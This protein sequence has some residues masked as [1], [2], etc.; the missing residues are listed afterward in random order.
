MAT[1]KVVAPPQGALP[2]I[3]S[4]SATK[5]VYFSKGNL[6]ATCT[7][8]GG[9]GT[10]TYSWNFAKHQYDYVGDKAGNTTIGS[11]EKGAVVDLFGWSSSDSRYGIKTATN[12]DDYY[13]DFVDWG[14][15]PTL[16]GNSAGDKWSTLSGSSGG[17]WR[18]LLDLRS[19]DKAPIIGTQ[20]NARYAEVKV[21]GTAGLLIFPDSFTWP[22]SVTS[23]PTTF[24]TCSSS[25]NEIDYT[26]ADFAILE[27]A[28]AVFLPTAGS[29]SGSKVESVGVAG[30]YWS[31]LMDD[32]TGAWYIFFG[33]GS[34]GTSASQARYLGFSVRLVTVVQ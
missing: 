32:N 12:Y 25:W 16:P 31:S 9:V 26:E 8:A 24:N 33:P 4:V 30:S 3:F 22:S 5:K 15:I 27:T 11:H 34:V 17:E 28:G 6:Q 21:K 7:N 18:Y 23:V 19:G 14:K 2:G 1:K 20:T 13:G 10:A 29:R